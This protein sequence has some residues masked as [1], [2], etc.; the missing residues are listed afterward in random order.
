MSLNSL[1]LTISSVTPPVGLPHDTR[2]KEILDLPNWL[3]VSANAASSKITVLFVD[4]NPPGVND[5][6]KIWLKP[7]TTSVPIDTSSTIYTTTPGI[8]W[9]DSPS[10]SWQLKAGLGI[11]V[12]TTAPTDTETLWLNT[13]DGASNI[14]LYW[15]NG[16]AWTQVAGQG[17]YV[18]ATAPTDTSRPWLKTDDTTTLRGLYVYQSSV[19]VAMTPGLTS[20]LPTGSTVVL[21]GA[22]RPDTSQRPY[23]LWAKNDTDPYG[24]FY[25]D[26]SLGMWVSVGMVTLAGRY[27]VSGSVN[28]TGS[29]GYTI[30]GVGYMGLGT[31]KFIGC[32]AMT[33]SVTYDNYTNLTEGLTFG[34]APEVVSGYSTVF[35]ITVYNAIAATRNI[36]VLYN[37][38]GRLAI[39]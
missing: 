18:G 11:F 9:Y 13:A 1:N 14:G 15:Y 6:D 35:D 32:P 4:P 8:Y 36:A 26:I 16:S 23:M 30:T 34:M 20:Q 10:G 38:T 2:Q 7:D 37:F 25:Y 28:V 12:G 21:T 17:I 29:A 39:P 19:W 33:V 27:P 5:H 22:T 31:G 3:R 24:M